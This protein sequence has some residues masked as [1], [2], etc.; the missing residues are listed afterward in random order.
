MKHKLHLR[1]WLSFLLLFVMSTSSWAEVVKIDGI[2]YDV[3]AKAKRAEVTKDPYAWFSSYSGNIVIPETVTYD[4][5]E[6]SVTSIGN[7]AFAE[8][9]DLTSVVIPNS[10]TSI[11]VGAFA[12]CSGLTSIT[13]PNSVT[14]IESGAFHACN[15]LVRAE[16]SSIESL[17]KI[18]FGGGYSE[19]YTPDES[20]PLKHAGHLFIDGQEVKDVV[21]PQTINTIGNYCFVGCSDLTSITIPNSV[22]SIGRYAFEECSGLTSITIPNSMTSIDD[23]A[24]Y[25]CSGLT[26]ITIPESVTSFGYN[27]FDHCFGLVSINVATGNTKYDSRGNCNAIIETE[28]NTLISG[29]KNTIIPNN[30]THI[31]PCA[32]RGCSGLISITI[33]ESVTPILYDLHESIGFYAFA[34]CVEL[35]DVYCLAKKVPSLSYSS[36]FQGSYVEY[37]T[38]HVPESAVDAYKAADQWKDFGTILPIDP[39]EV[40]ELKANNTPEAKADENAPIYDPNGRKLSK[41]PATGVY[42]QGGKKYFVK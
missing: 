32:F 15:G 2:F 14:S 17:C 36:V 34:D 24:F 25:N 4:G 19:S 22:T 40:D 9:Y 28:T 33:P 21:I 39:T 35:T 5:K 20:N 42:I 18:S 37:A 31:G 10:V 38:L 6:Y 13:I 12:S 1:Q 23:F 8:C 11:G 26:S 16:F 30:V 29:C 41:K 7:R 27:A 3:I